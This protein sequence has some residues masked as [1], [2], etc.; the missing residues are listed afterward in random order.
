[1]T[2]DLLTGRRNADP[3][4]V[5]KLEMWRIFLTLLNARAG[6]KGWI[7]PKEIAV[8][9]WILAQQGKVCYFSRPHS[10]DIMAQIENLSA[11]ELS[12]IKKRLLSARLIEEVLENGRVRTYPV[13]M[14]L[15]LK[16]NIEQ[17]QSIN[18]SFK[19]I[20]NGKD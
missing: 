4:S 8:L 20:V 15:R 3:V 1:M 5:S 12:R 10:D 2:Y 17:A 9:S 7:H 6:A 13:G 11:P 14:L 18:F 19:M 16:Q